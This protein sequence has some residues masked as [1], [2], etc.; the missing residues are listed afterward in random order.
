[1]VTTIQVDES[2]KR[3]LDNLKVHHRETYNELIARL[4]AGNSPKEFDRESLVATI[5]VLSDPE[6]MK[7]IREALEEEQRG[8]RGTPIE[9]V[10][11][12]LGL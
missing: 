1:M 12:E 3:K 6:L 8:E 11:R 9:D 7:G 10:R 4:V 2:L 5:E